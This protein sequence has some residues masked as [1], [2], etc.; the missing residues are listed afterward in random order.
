MVSMLTTFLSGVAVGFGL[1]VYVLL[2]LLSVNSLKKFD[3]P[4][5]I[6][7]RKNVYEEEPPTEENRKLLKD[8]LS[9]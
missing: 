2:R 7:N 9:T 5:E 3:E 1:A 8:P 6:Q 4:A